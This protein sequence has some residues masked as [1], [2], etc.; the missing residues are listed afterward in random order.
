[1]TDNVTGAPMIL[2]NWHVLAG[3]WRALPGQPILQPGRLD[4]GGAADAVAVLTRHAMNANLDAAVAAITGARGIIGEQLGVGGV[5]G[6]GSPY[7]GQSV[8]KSGRQTEITRGRVTGVLGMHPMRYGGLTRIIRDAFVIAP[9]QLLS[10]VSSGGDSGS[11]WLDAATG[12][13][14]GLHFA[15]TDLPERGLA[16]DLRSV[17][18]ALNVTLATGSD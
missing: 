11:L 4:G 9:S 12:E 16:M 7:L 13:A 8:I 18:M 1:M 5:R 6:V 2:S 10:T 14:V 15:G 17:L 3:D